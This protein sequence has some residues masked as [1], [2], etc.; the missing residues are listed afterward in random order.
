M[1]LTWPKS[2]G[3]TLNAH[4]NRKLMQ[5]LILL[6]TCSLFLFCK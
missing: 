3:L 2:C 6:R 4:M 5:P 1:H